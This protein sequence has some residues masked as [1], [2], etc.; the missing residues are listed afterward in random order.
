[1]IE[2]FEFTRFVLAAEPQDRGRG[3]GKRVND[4]P[5]LVMA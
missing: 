4:V 1:M 3:R 5:A 2:R